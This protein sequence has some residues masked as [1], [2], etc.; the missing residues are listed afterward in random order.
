MIHQTVRY[1]KQGASHRRRLRPPAT[2]AHVIDADRY[3]HD[4]RSKLTLADAK[5][6]TLQETNPDAAHTYEL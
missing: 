4:S 5:S 1:G 2:L 6:S 3:F